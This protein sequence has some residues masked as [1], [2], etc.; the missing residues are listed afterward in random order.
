MRYLTYDEYIDI[1]GA[2]EK[3]AFDRVIVR[4][5]GVIDLYTQNRMRNIPSLPETVKACIRDLCEHLYNNADTNGKTIT[6]K[7]QS[8]GGVSESENYATKSTD[9]TNAEIKYIVYDYLSSETDNHGTPLLYR[10][11]GV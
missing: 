10:G 3:I 7:S 9:E 6:S 5:C 1:G 11:C 2:L 4:A 8:A